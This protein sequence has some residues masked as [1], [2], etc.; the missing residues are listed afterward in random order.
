MGRILTNLKQ[1]Q[2]DDQQQPQRQQEPDKEPKIKKELFPNILTKDT[3]HIEFRKFQRDF[4][5]YFKE[6]YMEQ[7]SPEEQKHYLLKCL[8]ADLGERML[9]VTDATTPIFDVAGIQQN[10]ALPCSKRSITDGSR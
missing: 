8:D 10:P 4:I 1:I 3:S 7:A 5:V 9:A 2:H 6:S